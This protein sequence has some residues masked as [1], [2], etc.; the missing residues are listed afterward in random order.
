MLKKYV[1][2]TPFYNKLYKNKKARKN[3]LSGLQTDR[4]LDVG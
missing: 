1:K 2:A 4:M 3:E